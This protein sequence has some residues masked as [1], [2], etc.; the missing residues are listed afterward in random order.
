MFSFIWIIVGVIILGLYN[1]F[2]ILDNKTP[3]NDINNKIIKKKW[4]FCGAL[5][6]IYI[7][8]TISF[9]WGIIYIPL[10]LSTFWMLFA[11]IVHKI[12][13]K[14]PF[15]YIG[16]TAETDVLIKKVF[17]KKAEFIIIV[18]KILSLIG[19]IILVYLKNK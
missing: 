18:L 13:L 12:G 1:S 9:V 7:A 19:S 11:G 6:F 16:E 2:M 14:K 15:F 3:E 17:K 8:I 10:V 5:L 4:H